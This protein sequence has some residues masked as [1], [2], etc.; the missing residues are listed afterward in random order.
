MPQ[1]MQKR[2]LD[3]YCSF[4]LASRSLCVSATSGFS[5]AVRWQ[6]DD[7]CVSPYALGSVDAVDAM[8]YSLMLSMK[9][10]DRLSSVT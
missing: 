4:F 10:F 9:E 2:V 1:L 8:V 6:F 5:M 7:S 3:G